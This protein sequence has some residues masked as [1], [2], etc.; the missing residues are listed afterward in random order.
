M[1]ESVAK[2]QEL[3]LDAKKQTLESR[4]ALEETEAK[5]AR[6]DA[7]H[8]GV[9][10]SFPKT[11]EVINGIEANVAKMKDQ[12]EELGKLVGNI[13]S[14]R[15]GINDMYAL[16]ERFEAYIKEIH[17]LD[18]DHR[19]V[20]G[21]QR[22]EELLA[23]SRSLDYGEPLAMQNAVE[24]IAAWSRCCLY[25]HMGEFNITQGESPL[26][27]EELDRFAAFVEELPTRIHDASQLEIFR[28]KIRGFR[29]VNQAKKA[30]A[31]GRSLASVQDSLALIDEVEKF[32][33]TFSKFTSERLSYLRS[34]VLDEYNYLIVD[35]FDARRDYQDAEALFQIRGDFEKESIVHPDYRDAEDVHDFK[36]RF[37]KAEA[38]RMDEEAFSIAVYAYADS[39]RGKEEF[40]FE[41]LAH[42]LTLDTLSAEKKSFLLSA[43]NR[44]SFELQ[45][46]LLSLALTLGIQTE[47]QTAVL[48]GALACKDKRYDLEN[49]AKALRIC[50]EKLD[51]SLQKRF[52]ILLKNLLR[53]PK[54]H[55]VGSKSS[56]PDVHALYGED[57][58]NFRH[59]LGKPAPNTIV[60]P[61]DFSLKGIFFGFTLILPLILCGAGFGVLFALFGNNPIGRYL[62]VAPFVVALLVLHIFICLRYGR[63]E[64]GSAI[65]RRFLGIDAIINSAI[66]LV[67]FIAPTQL[68]FF[69]PVGITLLIVAG[70][71]C[72]WGFFLFKDKN[73]GWSFGIYVP[74][75]LCE[76][77]SLIF[78]ILGL[79][80]GTIG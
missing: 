73:K 18:R 12:R 55:R 69:A 16:E 2:T 47:E 58:D 45:I 26:S 23:L 20:E 34:V 40:E 33:S 22:V 79:M 53:S 5:L 43:I 44:M 62:L 36:L 54:A 52:R 32:R 29:C 27:E 49:G 11:S 24:E 39:T 35:A 10:V 13:A 57:P 42:Y 66:S 51:E 67:Y 60:K 8:L 61:W 46:E 30:L 28:D 41:V 63:D 65:Y 31:M 76:I 48:D 15:R 4:L 7:I 64:R 37:L 71:Q 70:T 14:I 1:S 38:V 50:C 9:D 3:L 6:I 25:E 72:L 80:N 74:L 17:Y 21:I 59:P 56:N 77:A 75:L 19:Y 68:A 78:L